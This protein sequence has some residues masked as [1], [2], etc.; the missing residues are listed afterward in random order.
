MRQ[1]FCRHISPPPT[2]SARK[3][4][5]QTTS[6]ND[7][8]ATTGITFN[9]VRRRADQVSKAPEFA[10][11]DAMFRALV[12]QTLA[13]IYVIRQDLQFFSYVNP[14]FAEIFGYQSPDEITNRIP[15]REF[16][17]PEHRERVMCNLKLRLD[18]KVKDM[19]YHFTGQRR[20]GTAI[21]LEVHGRLMEHLGE[22]AIIGM[23]LDVT[24]RKHAEQQLL[25]AGGIFAHMQEAV[26]ITDLNGHVISLNPSF[27]R[28][29]EY[30]AEEVLGKNLRLLQSGRQD[31]TFYQNMWQEIVERGHWQGE[32]WNRRKSGETYP[33]WLTINALRNAQNEVVN[34]IGVYVDIS[35]IN[36]SET[37]LEHLAH[38]DPLTGLPNRRQLDE[39][40][41][42]AIN[43]ARRTTGKFAVLFL[44]LDQFKKVNDIQ[45]HQ[46]GDELLQLAAQRM[47]DQLRSTDMLARLGGDEFMLILEDIAEQEGATRIARQLVH[48]LS[49]PFLLMNGSTVNIGCSIGISLY[50][51]NGETADTLTHRADIALYMAKEAGRGTYRFFNL[52]PPDCPAADSGS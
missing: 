52:Q 29:T 16:V 24:E 15:L 1:F 41:L 9:N 21:E 46:S 7:D 11:P 34:Y 35:R 10:V 30:T 27:T 39:R 49:E 8:C 14:V 45:G 25:L 50:P 43:R 6:A 51:A 26:A 5:T 23:L 20:D 17:A 32:I 48:A 18:G 22:S 28:T 38:H 40:L 31:E 13:G 33:E 2:I 36:H 44:D 19:R 12:E 37:H 3:I 4:G 42:L 47:L